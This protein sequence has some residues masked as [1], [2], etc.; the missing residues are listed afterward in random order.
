M[1]EGN[2]P[3]RS[4]A[5]GG[6]RRQDVLDYLQKTELEYEKQIEDLSLQ[7]DEYREKE[8]KEKKELVRLEERLA[9]E[10][11][12]VDRL[13]EE[14]LR[15]EE[16]L[17]QSRELAGEL[18][19][20][21]AHLRAQIDKLEPKAEAY[22]YL[23][24]QATEIEFDARERAQISL[25]QAKKKI[26]MLQEN[27]VQWMRSVQEKYKALSVDLNETFLA[28]KAELRRIAEALD[29]LSGELASHGADIDTLLREMEKREDKESSLG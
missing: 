4:S 9:E 15:S 29:Q 21:V 22:D 13:Q 12:R 5:F 26:G 18:D 11:S 28:S 6:F 20:E 3:F 19:K 16:A 1:G 27:S 14:L 23:K 2:Q 7:L 10:T 24:E 8:G 25:E 17:K